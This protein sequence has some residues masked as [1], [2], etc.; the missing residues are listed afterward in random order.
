METLK[1]C[2]AC[3]LPESYPGI[4]FDERGVCNYCLGHRNRRLRGKE[5]LRAR[6]EPYRDHAR[7]T[8]QPYDCIVAL[9]GGRDSTYVAHYAVRELGLRVLL[10]TFDNGF[11]P[12][13]TKQNLMNTARLLGMDHIVQESTQMMKNVKHV[14]SSW[15]HRPSPAMIGFLCTGCR[16]GYER[17]LASTAREHGLGLAITGGG[18]PEGRSF[19][20]RLLSPDQRVGKGLSLVRGALREVARNP[21]YVYDLGFVGRLA[22]EFF[23]RFGYKARAKTKMVSLFRYIAWDEARIVDVIQGELGWQKPSHS[24]SS[25]R[26]D[27]KVNEL[28]NY[29]YARTL[30]FTKHDTLLS[31]MVRSSSMSRERALERLSSDNVISETFLQGVVAELGTRF[32]DLDAALCAYHGTRAQA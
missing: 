16:T 14:L 28:K 27:C 18:E 15:V 24:S 4:T 30:G 17:G 20:Q 5:T 10:Y 32:D 8:G 21:R 12:E 22:T 1:R 6:I 25:W 2:S 13:Q 26:A 31:G 11:M 7:R 9:S 29:L 23:Y 3:V 19:A